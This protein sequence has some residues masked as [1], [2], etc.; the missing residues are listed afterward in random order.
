[1]VA[2]FA[3]VPRKVDVISDG[4]VLLDN[5]SNKS[6][7]FNEAIEGD[8]DGQED[9]TAELATEDTLLAADGDNADDAAVDEDDENVDKQDDP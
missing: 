6:F 3:T 7:I 1:M 2:L 4:S 5:W 9:N 8:D